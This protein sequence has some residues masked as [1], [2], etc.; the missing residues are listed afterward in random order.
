M[1]STVPI[2]TLQTLSGQQVC[3]AFGHALSAA[4]GWLVAAP[5][6][7]LEGSLTNLVDGCPVP[8]AEAC[9]VLDTR[10]KV[11]VDPADPGFST[12]VHRL[13]ALAGEG[14]R[15]SALPELK[16]LVFGH[17]LSGLRVAVSMD[18][19]FEVAHA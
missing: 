5:L 2:A 14:W 10:P 16:A 19:A 13:A 15:F 17:D 3:R 11:G 9:A 6:H 7:S 4:P 1:Q 12:A 8:W 18:L